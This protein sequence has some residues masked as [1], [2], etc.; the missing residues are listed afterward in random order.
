MAFVRWVHLPD[1]AQRK[2]LMIIYAERVE[3]TP[4][5]SLA[6]EEEALAN[7]K[8]RIRVDGR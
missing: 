8:K 6:Q 7:A 2:E 4:A 3:K 1:K 5:A